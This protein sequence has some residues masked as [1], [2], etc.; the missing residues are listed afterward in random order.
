MTHPKNDNIKLAVFSILLAVFAL[1]FGDAVIKHLSVAFSLWQ[2]YVVRSLIAIPILIAIIKIGEPTLSLVPSSIKWTAIRSLMLGCM[3]VAYYSALP[4]IKL[5]VA[6]A[7]YYTIPL[8]ITLFSAIFTGD[9]VGIKS[10]FAILL[11]FTGVL[12]ILRPASDDFNTYALLPLLAA[13]LYAL[14]MILTRTKCLHEN[15]KVLSLAL[16]VTFIIM[17]LVATLIVAIWMPD[18]ALKQIN[19]FLL[20]DWTQLSIKE[21]FAMVI[22]AIVIILGSLFAAV[23]YQNGPSSIIASLD[24]SYLAFSAIWGVLIFAEIPDGITILGMLIITSAGLLAIKK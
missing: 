20:G 1:S 23:A 12:I 7:V 17:G 5:S 16:S 4:H 11:G 6:A 14:A 2:I 9:K 8:F 3:W 19:P 21:W 15:P 10:W 24:Y 22:L 18:D 13:I